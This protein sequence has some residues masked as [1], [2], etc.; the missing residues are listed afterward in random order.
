MHAARARRAIK[1][2]GHV[3]IY[4]YIYT[5]TY[6]YIYRERER[7]RDTCMYV[8]IYIYISGH[9]NRA[10]AEDKLIRVACR[11][12]KKGNAKKQ[13]EADEKT[14]KQTKTK[15]PWRREKT[16]RAAPNQARAG[17]TEKASGRTSKQRSSCLSSCLAS[18]LRT[19]LD[20]EVLKGMFPWRTRYPL[21]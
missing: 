4:I 5:Y 21:S 14:T 16:K 2:A 19:C 1:A 6:I 17:R 11:V 10:E 18:S 12:Q 8:Y 15:Q 7:G 13:Q 9:S 20:C 3:Y